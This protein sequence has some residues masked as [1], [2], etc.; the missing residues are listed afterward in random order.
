MDSQ[1]NYFARINNHD[2]STHDGST[3]INDNEGMNFKFGYASN[4]QL[5]MTSATTKIL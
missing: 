4:P 5:K 1:I 2:Q 3:I